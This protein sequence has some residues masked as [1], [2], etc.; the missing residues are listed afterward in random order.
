MSSESDAEARG[1]WLGF[2]VFVAIA[3]LC[4]IIVSYM[5]A[6]ISCRFDVPKK[7]LVKNE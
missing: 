4:M 5:D 2:F 7:E 6:R 3:V 1:F